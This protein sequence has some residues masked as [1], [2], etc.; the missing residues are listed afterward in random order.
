MGGNESQVNKC[1]A[2][3]PIIFIHIMYIFTEHYNFLHAEYLFILYIFTIIE[4]HMNVHSL[5]DL[6]NIQVFN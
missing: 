2:V 6:L 4:N 5:Y 1:L 3:F